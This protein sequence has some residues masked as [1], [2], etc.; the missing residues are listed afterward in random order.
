M[1]LVALAACAFAEVHDQEAAEQ[2]YAINGYYPS[3]YSYGTYPATV[4]TGVP[5]LRNVAYPYTYGTY[6]AYGNTVYNRSINDDNIN[7][8]NILKGYPYVAVAAAAEKD[9]SKVVPAVK[10]YTYPYGYYNYVYWKLLKSEKNIYPRRQTTWIQN[11]HEK[12]KCKMKLNKKNY[13]ISILSLSL[14]CLLFH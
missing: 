10:T 2:F 13:L 5:T 12:I 8:N 6:P 3:W 11:L 1:V 4:A 7:V 14:N 9:A